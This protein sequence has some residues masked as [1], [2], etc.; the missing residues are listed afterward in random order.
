MVFSIT[1]LIVSLTL[2]QLT[3]PKPIHTT[4]NN[5]LHI[6]KMH[7][8]PLDPHRYLHSNHKISM[9]HI[10]SFHN[11]SALKLRRQLSKLH[12]LSQ[13]VR[14]IIRTHTML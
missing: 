8:E 6:Y 10:N 3:R 7:L 4:V 9:A 2:L 1:N 14:V 11:N 13:L 12:Q 5:I